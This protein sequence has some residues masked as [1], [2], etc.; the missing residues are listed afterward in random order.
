M[1]IICSSCKKVLG[2]QRPFN[3]NSEVPAKCPDCFQKE[4][5]EV[6]KLPPLPAPGER[7]D[8]TFESGLK[9]FLTVAGADTAKLSLWDLIVSGKKIFC[10]KDRRESFQEYLE[11]R[12]RDEVDVTFVYSSSIKIPSGDCRR[13]KQPIKKEKS[14]SI[15]YN[16]T[17]T[18]P[19][20]YAL[21]MF[22]S[23]A[24]R[25]EQFVDIVAEGI[26]KTEK[27]NW[28]GLLALQGR[29]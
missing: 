14:Q 27:D 20:G 8:I 10:A 29:L 21:M 2:I 16:C 23:V 4:K 9:G 18:V 5:E 7:K 24:E 28:L 22:D 17:V 26:V 12:D 11:M 25:Q 13:K 3:D 19:K 15:D 6:S 1:K